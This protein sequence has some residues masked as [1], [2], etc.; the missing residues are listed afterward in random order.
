MAALAMLV[1]VWLGRERPDD[2]TKRTLDEWAAAQGEKLEPPRAETGEA[3]DSS[4]AKAEPCEHLLE[5]ARDQLNAED[6]GGASRTLDRLEQT[7]RDHPELLQA[8][9]LMAERYRL[10]AQIAR[11]AGVSP[12][13]WLDAAEAL[14]GSRASAFGEDARGAESAPRITLGVVVHG[15]RTH[16]T[17]WDGVKT[18]DDFSTARGEHHLAIV[19]GK[20]VA[21]SGWVSALAPA[22]FD[23][24]IADAPACTIE[25]LEGATLAP[26]GREAEVPN[27]IRCPAWMLAAPGADRG[28]VRVALCREDRC[29][30][31]V[32]LAYDTVARAG[33]RGPPPSKGLPSWANWTLAG[34]GVAAATTLIMWRTGVFD[35]AE[36][37]PRV[38][39]DGSGL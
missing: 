24:W 15:A 29:R 9:W 12:D 27:G 21:W 26:G 7:L 18:D 10:E 6:D 13:S 22:T 33:E 36:P 14:E 19:R 17:Y 4:R 16:Q 2:R 37:A 1:F 32:T 23:V 3:S 35:R 20:R 8:S 39:Y 34:L 11:R 28:T 38:G 31:A 25:D 5:E 30:P